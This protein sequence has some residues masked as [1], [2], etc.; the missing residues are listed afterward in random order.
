MTVPCM[1]SIAVYL[2]CAMFILGVV[3]RVDASFVPST[4]IPLARTDRAADLATIQK[5][6][7]ARMVKTRL[8]E[9]GLTQ[10]EVSARLSRLSD[11]QLHK[12][13]QRLDNLKVG[14]DGGLGIVVTLLVIAILVVL[15]L[16]LT[17]HRVIVK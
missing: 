8:T 3:P 12:M 17:G 15:L 4:A 10:A 2:A 1:R 13:A 16:Q 5:V 9:L 7:E 11:Q 14:G 6:L